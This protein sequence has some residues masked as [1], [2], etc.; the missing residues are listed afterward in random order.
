MPPR[1]SLRRLRWLPPACLVAAADHRRQGSRRRD[2]VPP[3]RSSGIGGTARRPVSRSIRRGSRPPRLF[4]GS[5]ARRSTPYRLV[6]S[7]PSKLSQVPLA[8]MLAQVDEEVGG[9]AGL[10][11][12]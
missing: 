5:P 11:A 9:P 7:V 2:G 4:R 3:P 1:R 12:V 6:E 8:M 10:V